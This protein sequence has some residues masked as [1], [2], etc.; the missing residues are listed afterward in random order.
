MSVRQGIAAVLTASVR[1]RSSARPAR[2]S[3]TRDPGLIAPTMDQ[4]GWVY[5][6]PKDSPSGMRGREREGAR[7][8]LLADLPGTSVT[9]IEVSPDGTRMLVLGRDERRAGGVR[10]RHPAERGRVADR[11]HPHPLPGGSRWEHR[12][13]HRRDLGR[14]RRASPCWWRRRTTRPTG[15]SCSSSAAWAQRSG[16]PERDVDR[17]DQQRGRPPHPAAERRRVRVEPAAVAGGV[18]RRAEGV[19]PGRPA[20]TPSVPFLHRT[21]AAGAARGG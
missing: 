5:S 8:S 14:R 13:R 10:R 16:D 2:A 7:V 9:S 17:R 21:R 11:A 20:L 19:G 3:S 1:S 4:R 15:C 18:R 6:V 12:E